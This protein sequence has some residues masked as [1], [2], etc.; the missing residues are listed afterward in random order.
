MLAAVEVD[1]PRI[2]FLVQS[3]DRRSNNGISGGSL[4]IWDFQKYTDLGHSVAGCAALGP[5]AIGM[6][7]VP[8]ACVSVPPSL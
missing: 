3:G 8:Q 2:H 6:I 7:G 4:E 1:R 5:R